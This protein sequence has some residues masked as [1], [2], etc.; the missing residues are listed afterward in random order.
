MCW[1]RMV[2]RSPITATLDEASWRAASSDAWYEWTR[3]SCSNCNCTNWADEPVSLDKGWGDKC[4]AAVRMSSL[5]SWSCLEGEEEIVVVIVG[6]G[7]EVC[8]LLLDAVVAA[9]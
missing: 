9:G 5:S 2:C 1:A 3:W 8:T 6:R 4:S 7:G